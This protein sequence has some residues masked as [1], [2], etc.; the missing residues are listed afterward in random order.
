MVRAS[1]SQSNHGAE[2][3]LERQRR[4]QALL[5]RLRLPP[6]RLKASNGLPDPRQQLALSESLI[7]QLRR[8]CVFQAHGIGVRLPF[9]TD[10][11]V[12]QET[13]QQMVGFG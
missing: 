9:G 6:L 3:P 2:L 8:P 13:G 11:C 5:R 1:P 4:Q 12:E 7:R 10:T